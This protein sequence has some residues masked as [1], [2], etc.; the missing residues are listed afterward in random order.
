MNR[1]PK[2]LT[3]LPWQVRSHAQSDQFRGC[4]LA[5]AVG[6]ALGAPVEFMS[7][8]QI[9]DRFSPNG[10]TQYAPAYGGRG[11]ITD[12]TQMTLF[13]AEGLLR[14][15]VRGS[16]RGITTYTGVTSNA[17]LR[18][19]QTQE[20]N[21]QRGFDP[22]SEGGWLFQ[23]REL[24]SRRAPGNTCLSAL[25][26]MAKF[27]DPAT[28]DS[29]GC[30]GVM[31][32]APVGL[33]VWRKRQPHVDQKAVK[34]AFELGTQLAALT[35]GHPSG[36][37]TGGVF[38]VLI[39]ALADGATLSEALI[40]AKALL[41]E[42]RGGEES[43]SAI[44]QAEALATA[45]ESAERAIAEL[46]QGWVAEEALAIAI[47]CALAAP[48]LEQGLILA[49]N[50]D[51]DS[52]ST[53]SMTGNLLG[54]QYDIN[55][56]PSGWLEPLELREVIAEIAEDLYNFRSWPIGEYS[57]IEGEVELILRKYPGV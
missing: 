36:S 57:P 42:A 30:G 13:T 43:L 11:R 46:G 3:S 10:M 53:G 28:N 31:R 24:H 15:W 35:H 7:R 54:I 18:W 9:V 2:Y 29:K 12:D 37:L 34:E 41:S 32:S 16:M 44:E 40:A 55:A 52:D 27:G 47:Y 1:E 51:G 25:R 17:Y 26:A 19:L 23:Q 22:G 49:V 45:G 8:A 33:F 39:L 50:H 5:G 6:D 4:L 21:P 38:A 56:I 20:E 14:A 48:D